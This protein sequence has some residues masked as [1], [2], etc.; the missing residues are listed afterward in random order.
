MRAGSYRA[1][2]ILHLPHWDSTHPT[3][4]LYAD[5]RFN[6][7]IE[8]GHVW[9]Q[10]VPELPDEYLVCCAEDEKRD[11]LLQ[12]CTRVD[13]TGALADGATRHLLRRP[14]ACNTA[15][16][17]WPPSLV[18]DLHREVWVRYKRWLGRST[19]P[20]DIKEDSSRDAVQPAQNSNKRQRSSNSV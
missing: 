3:L 6:G 12:H 16:H 10:P 8:H 11:F 4:M 15:R 17:L 20:Q 13:A 18:F 1:D 5:R 2:H 7:S 19:E 14:A 9:F